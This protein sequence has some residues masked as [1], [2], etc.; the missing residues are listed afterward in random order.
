VRELIIVQLDDNATRSVEH[1]GPQATA[2]DG[3]RSSAMPPP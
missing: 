3:S 1:S 2:G